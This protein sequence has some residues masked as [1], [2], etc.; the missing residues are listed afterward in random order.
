M[1]RNGL[2]TLHLILIKDVMMGSGCA[3]QRIVCVVLV[4]VVVVLI[5]STFLYE[6]T[7]FVILGFLIVRF[8]FI[9]IN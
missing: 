8:E 1:R 6:I 9:F 7:R 3:S 5:V 2:F 4:I